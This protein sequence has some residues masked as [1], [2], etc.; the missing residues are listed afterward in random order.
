VASVIRFGL[1][2]EKGELNLVL[3]EIKVGQIVPSSRE[4]EGL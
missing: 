4:E 1:L 3:Q 2:A